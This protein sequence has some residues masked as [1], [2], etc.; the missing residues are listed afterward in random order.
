MTAWIPPACA[1][2]GKQ[3]VRPPAARRCWR[4]AHPGQPAQ[5]CRR[6]GS[7]LYQTGGLCQDCLFAG[8]RPAS[9]RTCFAFGIHGS[10]QVCTACRAF[11]RGRTAGQCAS[12]SRVA[13]L[14]QGRCRLCW[15]QAALARSPERRRDIRQFLEQPVRYHQLFFAGMLG[16]NRSAGL[17][18][19]ATQE[20]Q[21]EDVPRRPVMSGAPLALF[22]APS[23]DYSRFHREDADLSDPWLAYARHQAR[24]HGEAHGWT[25]QMRRCVDRGLIAVLAGHTSGERIRRSDLATFE[26]ANKIFGPRLAE[27]LDLLGLLDDDRLPVLEIR[28]ASATSGLTQGIRDDVQHWLIVLRDGASRHRPKSPLTV[29]NHL[30]AALPALTIW[31]GRY[32]HL[33]QVTR[34]DVIEIA[35]A[36]HGHDRKRTISALRSCSASA[37]V[38]AVSSATPPLVSREA[39]PVPASS[40][41][42][43]RPP[44]TTPFK[45]LPSQ[46][47]GLCWP[48]RPC[49]PP[50][51]TLSGTCS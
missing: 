33:R 50:G 43:T 34:R 8:E 37:R 10:G 2:C 16:H 13:P 27:I 21:G 9:C 49:M 32:Q 18:C 11:A 40:F 1:V 38:P 44:T 42:W 47:P 25:A 23:R 31:S 30:H 39:R 51:P 26:R 12:C 46:P 36:L 15:K 35:D 24:Q 20:T 5:L 17:G 48:S 6:C 4:C 45:P 3:P 28:I 22:E 14:K 29:Y 7:A 41:P 19:G